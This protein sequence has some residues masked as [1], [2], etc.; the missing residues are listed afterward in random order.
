MIW[1]MATSASMAV[2]PHARH[3]L[4]R[5]RRE[6]F[7]V[8]CAAGL[9]ADAL[10]LMTGRYPIRYG[11]QVGVVR[12]WAQYGLPLEE[13]MLSVALK[14]AGYSTAIV[15]KWHLG[16]IKPEYLHPPRFRPSVWL[17][18]RDR[19]F[20]HDRDGGLDWHRNDKAV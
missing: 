15:G 8:L 19:F 4:H 2:N 18:Q 11:F 13:R 6:A 16:H 5:R 10:A 7:A 12:P 17:L 3:R 20:T 14:E 9:L 1:A